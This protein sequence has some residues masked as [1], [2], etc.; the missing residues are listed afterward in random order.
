MGSDCISGFRGRIP[1]FRGS[2]FPGSINRVG[3]DG[4]ANCPPAASPGGTPMQDEPIPE[5]DFGVLERET[6]YLM[7]S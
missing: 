4:S 3:R 7:T 2:T 5:R 1:S 6:V